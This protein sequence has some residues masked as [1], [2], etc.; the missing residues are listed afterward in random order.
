MRNGLILTVVAWAILTPAT[1]AAQAAPGKSPRERLRTGLPMSYYHSLAREVDRAVRLTDEQAEAVSL[2]ADQ[3]QRDNMTLRRTYRNLRE[4]LAESRTLDASAPAA[5]REQLNQRIEQLRVQLRQQAAEGDPYTMF[6]E[7][8]DSILTQ[9]QRPLLAAMQT[10]LLE[11]R[12]VGSRIRQMLDD[13]P[14]ALDLD[15]QQ[16]LLLHRLREQMRSTLKT[17]RF[18]AAD[19]AEY[20]NELLAAEER[21]EFDVSDAMRAAATNAGPNPRASLEQFFGALEPAL[22]EDQKYKLFELRQS[23]LDPIHAR[24]VSVRTL[25]RTARWLDLTD[26][27]E[28][29]LRQIEAEQSRKARALRTEADATL[30][31]SRET[32]ARI[33]LILTEEQKTAF[34]ELLEHARPQNR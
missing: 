21:G 23:V 16:Q 17:P 26:A 3:H 13:L 4:A 29:Q 12:L 1:A 32:E 14:Q 18:A 8:V 15:E 34:T 22:R 20:E 24:Q 25:L 6:F 5:Q 33:R 27:Q 7:D 31:L 11:D 19:P 2:L 9:E 10:R 30:E 28:E